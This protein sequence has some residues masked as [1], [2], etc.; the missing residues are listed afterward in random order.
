MSTTPNKKYDVVFK[1][2]AGKNTPQIGDPSNVQVGDAIE[3][4]TPRGYRVRI[5]KQVF[6]RAKKV[7]TESDVYGKTVLYR[8]ETV[9]FEEFLGVLRP[10]TEQ[11]EAPTD[12]PKAD[13]LPVAKV[14][15]KEEPF[16][17]PWLQK[18]SS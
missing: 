9:R 6:P 8:G 16:V 3:F 11:A 1:R 2:S 13:E 12:V 10:K 15:E 14:A 17:P 7:K 4:N 5:V 18:D